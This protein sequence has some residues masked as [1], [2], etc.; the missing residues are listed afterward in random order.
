MNYRTLDSGKRRE[1]ETGARRDADAGKPRYELLPQS[2]LKRW[3]LLM[4]RGAE[5]YGDRDWERGMPVSIF[6][7]SAFRHLQQWAEGDLVEDHLAGV[8]FNVAAIMEM[9]ARVQSGTLE[10]RYLDEGA[11]METIAERRR[12]RF[13]KIIKHYEEIRKEFREI[14]HRHGDIFFV[15]DTKVLLMPG[16]EFDE[17]SDNAIVGWILHELG[18][19]S[20]KVGV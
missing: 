7:A 17:R 20:Y 6:Y 18:L 2:A 11:S 4:G 15:F 1:F 14:V 16:K 5:K 12:V 13:D 10:A 3:A 9:E 8:L 19:T